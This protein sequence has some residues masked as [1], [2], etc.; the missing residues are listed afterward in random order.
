MR[1][2]VPEWRAL[3]HGGALDAMLTSL[4]GADAVGAQRD[5]YDALLL[6]FAARFGE[7]RPAAIFSAPGRTEIGGNHTDHQRGRVLAAAVTMDC[8]AVAAPNGEGRI[9]LESEGYAPLGLSLDR[10]TPIA[11]E[12]NTSAALLRGVAAG[13]KQRGHVIG[14]FDAVIGSNVPGGAGLSSSAAYA[15]LLGNCMTGLYEGAA[16]DAVELAQVA[17]QAENAFFGKP[18][19]LMDQLASS[20][21]GFVTIDFFDET[22]PRVERIP[23]DLSDLGLAVCLVNT[24]GSHAD[25]THEYAA[26]PQDMHLVARWFGRGVLAEVDPNAFYAALPA[27]RESVSDLALLRAMHFFSENA[28]VPEQAA[29]LRGGDAARFLALVRASGRS[30]FALLQ[31]ICPMD[32]AERGLALA[33]ALTERFFTDC[34]HGTPDWASGSKAAEGKPGMRDSVLCGTPDW[35]SGSKAAEGKPGIRDSV[36]REMPDWASGSKAAEGK[37][38]IRDSVLSGTPDWASGS[39]AAEGK[40]GIRDSVFRE[41]P[42]WASRVHGGGFAGAIQTFVPLDCAAAYAAYMERVFGPGSCYRVSVRPVG[43]VML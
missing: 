35:A 42:V 36:F 7:D 2:T 37:P 25:L 40:P 34:A 23:V 16:G 10:L 39:K 32:R 41:M 22:A 17:R 15:V 21:G 33:L 3:L 6:R 28:R 30:S 24:G 29:A 12:R 14:G 8:A 19:G 27:L 20:V 11:A 4:Y 1:R 18:S 26:I 43:G 13:L 31:N 38:G 5:R 9:T